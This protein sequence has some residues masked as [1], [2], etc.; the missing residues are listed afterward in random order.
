MTTEEQ[1]AFNKPQNSSSAAQQPLPVSPDEN[2]E[3]KRPVSILPAYDR[4]QK[5]LGDPKSSP[6]EIGNTLMM[7]KHART[8]PA[9]LQ[10]AMNKP[11]VPIHQVVQA[12][13]QHAEMNPDQAMGRLKP[14]LRGLT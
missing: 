3:D 1:T 7:L 10:D 5:V 11:S 12:L 9:Y 4:I 13:H 8:L 2:L 6:E 14:V